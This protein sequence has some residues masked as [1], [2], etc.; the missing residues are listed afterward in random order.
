MTILKAS[1]VHKTF[2]KTGLTTEV[3]KGIDLTIE[4]GEFVAI[5][6]P[7]GSGK[8]TLLYLFGGLD[9]PSQ[10]EI[11]IQDR[12]T[13]KMTDF[14]LAKM[15]NEEIGFVFQ[16]HFLLPELTALENVVVPMLIRGESLKKAQGLAMEIL[17]RVGMGHRAKHYPKQMSGGEQQRV[18]IARALINRPAILLGDELT[19]NLDT[20]NSK[21]IYDLLRDCHKEFNQTIVLITHNTELAKMADRTIAIIDGQVQSDQR[22]S[23]T[24]TLS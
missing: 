6:G 4:K 5:T 13:A 10:G 20:Q 24:E 14:D 19:G 16:F 3:L 17:E 1:N 21:E 9:R 23:V 2:G 12:P 8:S 18:A 7:S 15:R 11:Y 22:N